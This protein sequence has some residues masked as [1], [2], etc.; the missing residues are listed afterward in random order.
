MAG[1][2][3]DQSCDGVK[4]VDLSRLRAIVKSH[5]EKH[6]YE[7][8]LFWADKVVSLSNG[9]VADVYTYAQ[10][11]F[12]T[13][14]YHR[15]AYLITNRKLEKTNAACRFL[16]AKCHYECK[17]YQEALEVLDS[18][19]TPGTGGIRRSIIKEQVESQDESGE[20]LN[21]MSSSIHLLRGKI[22][23]ALDNRNLAVECLREALREDVYNFEAFDAMIGHHML[24][25]SEE[26][27]LLDSLP[28]SQQCPEEETELIRFLYENRLKKYNKPQELAIPTSLN[29]L[30]DNLDIVVNTAERHYYNCDFRECHKVTSMVLA[31]DP[32]NSRCLPLHIAVLVELHQSNNLFYLAHKLV[33]LYP[34]KAVA[35]FAVGCYY[36]LVGKHDPARRYFSKATS[37]DRVY[38]PAWLAFGH[39][40]AADNE[41]DQ[42]MAAYFTASQL[43]K[44]CHLPVLY[45]GLE[46]G[47][48]NNSKLAER[49]FQQALN[50]APEDP[51]VL[52]E[53]GVIA[54]HNQDWVAAEKYFQDALEKIRCVTPDVMIEKWESLLNNLGHVSRK[55]KKYEEALEYH[56]QAL[57]VSPQTP[58]TYS[59]IGYVYALQG[60]C[61]AAVDYFHKA[62]GLRR[63]DTF[64][65]TMLSNAVEE[66]MG[67]M[68]PC[69]GLP[70]VLPEYKT[71]NRLDFSSVSES[72]HQLS[73]PEDTPIQSTPGGASASD[74]ATLDGSSM[75]IEEI[76]ME[77]ND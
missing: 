15:A 77:E 44:G 22:Y 18:S 24:M 29:K 20:P 23:E 46:Y 43:M 11:L 35:W 2:V 32:Y 71:E 55:L 67:D 31:K 17:E 50:V 4:S 37:L 19:E 9:E 25:A 28:F 40:F 10:T 3:E 38:G 65:T 13:K 16:V 7:S 60:N 49:F 63:D 57:I 12:L 66:L 5:I 45:I 21:K 1:E 33:D 68:F 62:L 73:Q 64:S 51:F 47:L 59:A 48:T 41:H 39:S 34:N 69:D 76:E 70:D 36:Y 61:H 27:E 54:F 72:D 26:K 42:A 8:A 75:A 6:Q 53:M 14:Q 74:T 58:S 52:H 56:R 30:H